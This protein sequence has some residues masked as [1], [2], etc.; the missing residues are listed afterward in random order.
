M[1]LLNL[2]PAR[3]AGG[4]RLDDHWVWCGSCARD[5]EGRYHLFASRWPRRYPMHPGWV[6]HSE[7]VRAVADDPEGPYQFAEVVLPRRDP[8]Y[9]DGQATHNPSIHRCG[10]MW[11]LFYTGITYPDPPPDPAALPAGGSLSYALA[12]GMK[13]IGLATAPAPNGPWTRRDECILD[14]RSGHWDNGLTSNPAPC[15][16]PDGR[17]VLL[18]KSSHRNGHSGGPFALGLAGAEHWSKPFAR[19]HGE[20]VLRFPHGHVEDPFLW[21]DGRGFRVVAKDMTGTLSG[22]KHGGLA[23]SSGDGVHWQIDGPAYSRRIVW[24]DGEAEVMGAL[25]RPFLL[26]DDRGRPSHLFAA[27]GSGPGGFARCERTWN[28]VLPVAH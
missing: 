1:A 15:V 7:V 4:F 2:G 5:D 13:R 6:F 10:N 21:H 24:D 8:A 18:Y 14:V 25:E 3:R 12:W 23:A 16:F 22:E 19:L 27:T 17:V 28:V 9:F 11:L 26:R 20:P